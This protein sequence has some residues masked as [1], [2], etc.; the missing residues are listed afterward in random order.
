[1][2]LKRKIVVVIITLISV[3]LFGL[4][5][6]Q[7][8]LLQRAYQLELSI[9]K[10]NVNSALS[11]IVQKLE[12]RETVAKIFKVTVGIE[13]AGPQQLGVISINTTDSLKTADDFCWAGKT[14]K[15]QKVRLDS[16]KIIF[17]LDQP[18]YVRL[19]IIDSLGQ[20]VKKILDEK[21]PAG[22]YTV[23]IDDS[24]SNSGSFF[25]SFNTDSETYVLHSSRKKFNGAVQTVS[26]DKSKRL[27]VER[28]LENLSQADHIPVE[29]RINPALLDTVVAETL[30]EKGFTTPFVYG[31]ISA[32]KDSVILVSEAR[33]QKE[34]A[35]TRYKT[36]L[37]PH[38]VFL[39][40]N[41]IAL[42]FPQQTLYLIRQ[43]GIAALLMLVFLLIII[44][45]FGYVIQTIFRQQKFSELL[46]DFINNMTHEF[47]TPIST[48]ALTS[49]TMN[50]P[51]VLRDLVKLKKYGKIIHDESVRMRQQVE[52]ILQLAALE[53]GDVELNWAAVDLHDVIHHCI[54]NFKI[55]LEQKNGEIKFFP[56]ATSAIVEADRVHLENIIHNLLDNALKYSA[57][58]PVIE[59]TTKNTGDWIRISVRDFGIGIAPENQKRVFEKYFRVPTGNVH[60]VKG[61]GLG[62]S[63]VKLMVEAHRGEIKLDSEPGKGSLFEIILP[64]K[65][66]HM[67]HSTK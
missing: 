60:D 7:I 55:K 65:L 29:K 6:L 48:I 9:F 26:D 39:E 12:T 63:Y 67:E 52:K 40:K 17:Q 8:L 28:V 50:N 10:Q 66:E 16:G 53:Q 35:A 30:R 15:F 36:R 27:L 32:P 33:F 24:F 62:L 42:Y 11:S 25:F 1:M 61:F 22:N 54:H 38:D 51:V 64:L 5:V 59:I 21:K 18:Q 31:V 3:A 58:D 57:G 46:V 20:Q 14:D 56:N 37:F 43:T 34:L 44:F 19:R 13:N 45:C 23:A 49:E 47:K 4:M 2:K 41:D